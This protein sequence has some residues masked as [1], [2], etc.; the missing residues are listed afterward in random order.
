MH[1][2][3]NVCDDEATANATL[4]AAVGAP[5]PNAEPER[6]RAHEA[7]MDGRQ[8]REELG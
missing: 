7:V 2:I 6:A 3:Y 8:L 4:F 5:P 1:R